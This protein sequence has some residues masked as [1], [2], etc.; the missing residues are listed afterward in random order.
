MS[1]IN[2]NVIGKKFWLNAGDSGVEHCCEIVGIID[3][4]LQ[5]IPESCCCHE[6]QG[7]GYTYSDEYGGCPKCN[8]SDPWLE[9]I[10]NGELIE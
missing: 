2:S 9:S 3:N 8:P 4:F 5:L 1:K 6:D 7:Y 10:D